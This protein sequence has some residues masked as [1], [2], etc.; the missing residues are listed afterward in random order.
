MM[1]VQ[2]V[3]YFR[4]EDVPGEYFECS[5]YGSM[6]TAA[7]ARNFIEAPQ[8]VRSGRLRHCIG[9]AAGRQHAGADAP[10]AASTPA[11]SLVYRV[12]C[13]RCRRDARAEGTRLIGRL[14]LVRDHTICVSCY[15]RER[16]VAIGANAK[17]AQPKKW[18]GLYH[19]RIAY[20]AGTRTVVAAPAHP[21]VDHVEAML[22]MIRRGRRGVAWAKPE[23]TRMAIEG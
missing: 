20:L 6:S 10:R 21:I 7:C 3:R 12:A 23:I 2:A 17:G 13:C 5:S 11:S 14:R 19:A 18:V 15:N 8:V 4:L 16:E 1:S 22:T 9:C